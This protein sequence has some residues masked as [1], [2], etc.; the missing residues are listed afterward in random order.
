[1]PNNNAS[2]LHYLPD[3]KVES[4]YIQLTCAEEVLLLVK[5]LKS[6]CSGPDSLSTY[7][8]KKTITHYTDHLVHT[9]NH[10]IL[11]QKLNHYGIRG[12]CLKWIKI[13]LTNRKQEV[14]DNGIRSSELEVK[15]GVP[16]GSILGPL[17]FII[18][19]NDLSS[20]SS[21]LTP[22]MYADDSSFFLLPTQ[23]QFRYRC[24]GMISVIN[25]EVG[26][27]LTWLEV[28]RLSLNSKKSKWTLFKCGNKKLQVQPNLKIKIRGEEIDQVDH[29]QFL[30]ISLDEKLSWK[31]HLNYISTK[32]AKCIGILGKANK[33]PCKKLL[34]TLYY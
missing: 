14:L 4:V 13:Y 32:L 19:I 3:R 22:I 12:I 2:P 27:I 31:K 29:I 6:S 30:G 8:I 10:D 5:Q 26:K 16:Q 23:H 28:N 1:M 33:Y 18:D 20:I 24:V 15:C 25:S 17:L 21:F 34:L 11:L 9:I 7:L